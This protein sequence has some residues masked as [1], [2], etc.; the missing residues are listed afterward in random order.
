MAIYAKRNT[1]AAILLARL[2]GH[3]LGVHRPGSGFPG[4]DYYTSWDDGEYWIK[5]ALNILTNSNDSMDE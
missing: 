2:S 4:T 5:Q 1:D 3:E